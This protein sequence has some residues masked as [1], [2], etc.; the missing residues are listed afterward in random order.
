MYGGEDSDFSKNCKRVTF[1]KKKLQITI[2]IYATVFSS[3][4]CDLKRPFQLQHLIL[5]SYFL[6][7]LQTASLAFLIQNELNYA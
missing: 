5:I 1:E 3:L 2:Q 4:R 7:P 6:S